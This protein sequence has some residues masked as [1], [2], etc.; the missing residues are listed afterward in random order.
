M[1]TSFQEF[2]YNCELYI[3]GSVGFWIN[4]CTYGLGFKNERPNICI[5]FFSHDGC[6]CCD[7]WLSLTW[8]KSTYRKVRIFKTSLHLF[9]NQLFLKLLVFIINIIYFLRPSSHVCG[10]LSSYVKSLTNMN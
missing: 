9:K 4:C 3:A 8:R 5:F 10:M 6:N 7:S 2:I 1:V